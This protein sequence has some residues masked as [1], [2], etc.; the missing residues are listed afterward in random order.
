MEPTRV[1]DRTRARLIRGRRG[2]PSGRKSESDEQKPTRHQTQREQLTP[3][4]RGAGFSRP[5]PVCR[6]SPDYDQL[7]EEVANDL[8]ANKTPQNRQG[9]IVARAARSADS[10]MADHPSFLSWQESRYRTSFGLS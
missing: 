10:V 7:A 9:F 5:P 4:S 3:K 8:W 6:N 1:R 2:L